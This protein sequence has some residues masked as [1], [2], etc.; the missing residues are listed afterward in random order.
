MHRTALA[1]SL[2]L[3]PPT[4]APPTTARAQD[5]PGVL[6]DRIPPAATDGRIDDYLED[7]V[8]YRLA[9]GATRGRLFVFLPGSFGRPTQVQL[10]L[11]E[12]ARAGYHAVGLRYPNRW[13]VAGLCRNR[14]DPRCFDHVRSEIFDGTDRSPLV[15]VRRPNSIENR[16]EKLL[17]FLETEFPGQGWAQFLTEGGQVDW[18][19]TVVAGHSQGGGH[20]AFM[21][22]DR[23]L[24]G[25]LMFGSPADSSRA[26]RRPALWLG[27]PHRTPTS[28]Y[29]AFSHEDDNPT[30]QLAAWRALGLDGFGETVVVEASSSPFEGSHMLLTNAPPAIRGR[31]HG[32]VVADRAV[33]LDPQGSPLH[34]PIWRHLLEEVGRGTSLTLLD[35]RFEVSASWRRPNGSSGA[36]TGV[37]LTSDSGYFWFFRPE[38]VELVVKTLDG[39]ASNDHFWVLAGGLTNIEVELTVQD[40]E[41]G[42]QVLYGNPQGTPFQPIQDTSAFATCD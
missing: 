22:R 41:T 39:C 16:L 33:P 5:P 20:A 30:N 18:A 2:L 4:M 29:Y 23:L 14:R 25:V 32:S 40:L 31:E 7:H 19:H 26:F 15:D 13:T 17:T 35:S 9:G 1:L 42:L 6:V 10:I 11:E 12:A 36:G 37:A 34:R 24:A 27:D 28:R 3:A 21:G 8:V 38:N